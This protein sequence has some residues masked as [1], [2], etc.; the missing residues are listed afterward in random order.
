MA[1][2]SPR[3]QALSNV[4]IFSGLTKKDLTSIQRIMS[5][6]QI[7]AGEE[8]I[9]EGTVGRSAFIIVSGTASVWKGGK[10][11]TSVG[12]GAIIGEM[13]LLAGTPCNSTVRAESDLMV[14]ALDKREFSS[15]LDTD[16]AVT[17]RVLKASIV[18]LLETDPSLLS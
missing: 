13:S 2:Q 18:R 16:V 3:E 4:P 15:F 10:L 8:F 14:E 7:A 6:M 5:K 12:P 17:R 9:T 11:I 1:K